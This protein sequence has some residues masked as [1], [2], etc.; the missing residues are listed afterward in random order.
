MAARVITVAV[1][2]TGDIPIVQKII[3]SCGFA[4]GPIYGLMGKGRLDR[5]LR[6]CPDQESSSDA[7][8]PNALPHCR[9]LC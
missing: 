6:A 8:G 3:E 4:L 5:R 9:S 1:E 2:G 7:I